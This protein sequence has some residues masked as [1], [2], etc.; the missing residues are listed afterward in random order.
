MP[1]IYVCG[2]YRDPNERGVVENIRAAEAVAIRLWQI[3]CAAICP[4]MNTALMGG[5]VPDDV[6]IDGDL[7][8]LERCDAVLTLR[9]WQGS[10]GSRAEV[11]YA[12]HKGV[13]V[14]HEI[15]ELQMWLP[16]WNPCGPDERLETATRSGGMQ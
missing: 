3:G 12:R 6:F 9:G 7:N 5:V 1:V 4:H 16:K 11:A 15:E 2:P 13:L 10:V 14:F 8:I